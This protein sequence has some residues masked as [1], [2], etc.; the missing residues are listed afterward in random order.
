MELITNVGV[1]AFLDDFTQNSQTIIL[2]EGKEKTELIDIAKK[3]GVLVKNS[4]DLGILKT[5]Y[6]FTD[7]ANEN[8]AILPEKAMLEVLPT[9]IGKPMNR[10]HIRDQIRGVY[11]DYK[12]I[13]NKKMIIAYATFFKSIF[14]EEWD[15][16]KKLQKQGRLATSFEIWSPKEDRKYINKNTYEMYNMEIAGGGLLFNSKEDPIPPAFPGAKV[17]SMS[18]LKE[19]VGDTCLV[20]ATKEYDTKELICSEEIIPPSTIKCGNCNYDFNSTII[21]LNTKCPKCGAILNTN[22]I[23]LYPPQTIDFSLSCLNCKASNW[24]VETRDESYATIRCLSCNKTYGIEFQESNKKLFDFPLASIL[25]NLPEKTFTCPQCQTKLNISNVKELS[26]GKVSLKCFNCDLTFSSSIFDNKKVTIKS[27]K[28]IEINNKEEEEEMQNSQIND[29]NIEYSVDFFN[30]YR[31]D[32]ENTIEIETAEKFNCECIKCG[33][34]KTTEQHCKDL[35]CPKCGG[36]MRRAERPGSGQPNDVTSKRLSY[37]ERKALPDAQFA[38]VIDLVKI[39][40]QKKKKKKKKIRMF[41]I[42]DK[43]HVRNALS[44]LSQDKIKNTLKKYK[45]SIDSVKLKI[46]KR[47]KE[48]EMTDLL[49][50]YNKAE[51]ERIEKAVMSKFYD[52]KIFTLK[53]G[54]RKAVTKIIEL[55]KA[56]KTI[57]DYEKELANIKEKQIKILNNKD[58]E[59]ASLK[60]KINLYKSN[61]IKIAERRKE[62]G[63]FAQELTD[64]DLLNDKEYENACLKLSL[65]MKDEE[66]DKEIIESKKK[67]TN[68]RQK[69]LAEKAIDNVAFS[70]E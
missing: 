59:L 69:S 35:K 48:L 34:K 65:A 1:Q 56:V 11:V 70:Q 15:E 43:A 46:L 49:K 67:K 6:A 23:V 12:Y 21:E 5:I 25:E 50:K 45:I 62:L 47:A 9:M 53:S 66:E 8:G 20:C 61:G 32:L 37:K 24:I 26:Q 14:S 28:D 57:T 60:E 30:F 42:H 17:L 7:K 55:K 36:Q 44:R 2:E 13:K 51:K 33:Y 58:K 63:D 41:P 38:I 68:N 39:V 40:P 4:T 52:E 64:E 54:I 18:K 31:E 19:C 16:A 3:R 29:K 22:G 27:I 10:N